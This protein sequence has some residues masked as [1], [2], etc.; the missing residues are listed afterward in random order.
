LTELIARVEQKDPDLAKE[1][2]SQVS[3]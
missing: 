1:L 3:N 2:M